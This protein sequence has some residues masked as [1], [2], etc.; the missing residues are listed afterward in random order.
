MVGPKELLTPEQYKRWYARH[1]VVE[2]QRLWKIKNEANPIKALPESQRGP[3]PETYSLAEMFWHPVA[4]ECGSCSCPIA[5]RIK[6]YR[7]SL[8]PVPPAVKALTSYLPELPSQVQS[9]L[10]AFEEEVR[11]TGDSRS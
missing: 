8:K 9:R 2:R 11:S 10:Q 7:L 6:D 4:C 1:K 5:K 3:L